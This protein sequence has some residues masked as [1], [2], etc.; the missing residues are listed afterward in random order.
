VAGDAHGF[1][2]VVPIP[3]IWPVVHC[4]AAVVGWNVVAAEMTEPD[5]VAAS[6][7]RFGAA[8]AGWIGWGSA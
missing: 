2:A 1:V 7:A 5:F 6:V 3:V 4:V 8:A